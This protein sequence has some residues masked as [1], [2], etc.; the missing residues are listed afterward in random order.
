[1][2]KTKSKTK[3]KTI[4]KRTITIQLK[5]KFIHNILSSWKKYTSGNVT[6]DSTTIYKYD[7]YL[8]FSKIEDQFNHIHLILHNFHYDNN[9]HNNIIYVMKKFDKEK[10]QIIHSKQIKINILSNPD[11]V[12]INMIKNYDKFINGFLHT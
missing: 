5:T 6:K 2:N 12:V 8:S 4:K 7:Y 10:Q 11:K 9:N 3:S 1:M